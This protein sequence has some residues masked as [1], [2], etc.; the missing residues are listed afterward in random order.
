MECWN[1]QMKTNVDI[2]DHSRRRR[3]GPTLRF[4]YRL[5]VDA[6]SAFARDYVSL[7]TSPLVGT[8]NDPEIA[9]ETIRRSETNRSCGTKPL[10]GAPQPLPLPGTSSSGERTNE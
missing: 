1:S 4:A 6:Y 7:V 10:A 2:L 3:L 5:A 8:P 9:G